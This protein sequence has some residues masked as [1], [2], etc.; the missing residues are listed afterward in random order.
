MDV[1]EAILHFMKKFDLTDDEIKAYL[2]VLGAGRLALGD[3]STL[4]GLPV[5]VCKDILDRLVESRFV[6]RVPGE[7]DGFVPLNPFLAGFLIVYEDLSHLLEELQKVAR[8]RFEELS[9]KLEDGKLLSVEELSRLTSSRVETFRS[10]VEE[11]TKLMSSNFERSADAFRDLSVSVEEAIRS[12]LSTSFFDFSDVERFEEKK[13]FSLSD[14][15]SEFVSGI[16][17][18]MVSLENLA[19]KTFSA[20]TKEI[21][22]RLDIIKLHFITT[23]NEHRSKHEKNSLEL[24]SKIRTTVNENLNVLKSFIE[25]L[26]SDVFEIIKIILEIVGEKVES[27]K[28]KYLEAMTGLLNH[29]LDALNS[30]EPR[31]KGI[32]S[33]LESI[34]Q[35]LA[36][37]TSI[38]SSRRK[39]FTNVVLKGDA[40]LEDL[41]EKTQKIYETAKGLSAD[42]QSVVSEQ[43]VTA[44]EITDQI[45]K[46]LSTFVDEKATLVREEVN[47]VQN[48]FREKITPTSSLI[49]SKIS[50]AVTEVIKNNNEDC[51]N[52]CTQLGKDIGNHIENAFKNFSEALTTFING[53]SELFSTYKDNIKNRIKLLEYS[54]IHLQRRIAQMLQTNAFEY[55][56]MTEELY[57]NLDKTINQKIGAHIQELGPFEEK[58]AYTISK[59]YTDAKDVLDKNFHDLIEKFSSITTH[60][61]KKEEILKKIWETSYSLF[62]KDIKTWPLIGEKAIIAHTKSII[63]KTKKNITI[64][65]PELIP[66]ILEELLNIRNFKATIISNIDFKVFESVIKHF[67]RQGNVKFL[68][69]PNKDL[70]CVVRDRDETIFAPVTTKEEAYAI[71]SEQDGYINF[72][73]EQIIPMVLSKSKEVKV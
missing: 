52:L 29:Y 60:I 39:A 69:Y 72:T 67:Q 53:S 1:N 12:L 23:L 35:D 26:E 71:V 51:E 40:F 62:D 18:D 49:E 24:D 30:F 47:K 13:S 7:V 6:R 20:Y 64:I 21:R 57:N 14:L 42:Y 61:E 45:T 54:V 34:S 9:K 8:T 56:R 15:T 22:E 55:D 65:S 4:T 27:F 70:W 5:D 58:I 63:R 73:Q 41:N 28:A 2:A 59:N 3:V 68:H 16:E 44:Q 46:S 43:I 50:N 10:F 25:H 32:I 11:F 19:S 36:G 17:Q 48:K 31:V 33:G 38:L 66:E 37:S